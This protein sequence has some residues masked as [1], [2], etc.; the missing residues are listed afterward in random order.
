[1]SKKYNDFWGIDMKVLVVGAGAREAAFATKLADTCSVSA[2]MRH[3]NPT[4]KHFVEKTGGKFLVGDHCDP[5]VVADFAVETGIELA[6]VS[7]DEPLARGVVDGLL[8][9]NIK[10][11][12]PT[13]SAAEIEWNKSF[14]MDLVQEIAPSMNPWFEIGHSKD[15]LREI[16]ERVEAQGLEVVVKPQGLTGGRGVKVMGEHFST[17]EEGLTYASDI[18][19]PDALDVLIVEKIKGVEFTIMAIT[20]GQSVVFSPPTYDYPY[21]NEGDK[22][23]GT[24]GMG[25]YSDRFG[26]LPFLTEQLIEQ[27]HDLISKT[28]AELNRQGRD[29][30]GVLN[31]GLF[32]T[33]NGIKFMEYNARF[34]DPEAMNI[35]ILMKTPFIEVLEKIHARQLDPSSV[36]FE[37]KASV[38]KYLVSPEYPR[39]SKRQYEFTMDVAA[40]NNDNGFVFFGSA[41]E[42]DNPDSYS[43]V[44]TSR[45]VAVATLADTISEAASHVDAMLEQHVVGEL[46]FRRDIGSA[47]DIEK[48][49]SLLS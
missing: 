5:Q 9:S 40:C 23:P 15:E 24:G 26:T 46:Q 13:Q 18:L 49:V 20:D 2:V 8:S 11:V 36:A 45:T 14:A 33:S 44:G 25:C 17:Y 3:A 21:R 19:C 29:F 35:M 42:R 31:A 28:L 32:A 30:N 27:S 7:S 41:E 1:M 38:V 43:T 48:T 10:T 4:T 39:S 6:F 16:F 12:G 22:G 34:G 47:G 37:D